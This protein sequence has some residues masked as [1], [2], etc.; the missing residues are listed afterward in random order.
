MLSSITPL[1]ERG[2]GNRWW[3]TVTAYLLGSVVGG[4]AL[5]LLAGTV[6]LAVARV[7]PDG[8]TLW[9]LAAGCLLAAV[10]DLGG[11][12]PPSWRRQVDEQWLHAF[13]G[14][15]YGFGFGVQ[16]GFGLVTIVTSAA[17][18]AAVLSMVLTGSPVAGALV[19]AVFGLARGLPVLAARR[20]VDTDSL[21]DL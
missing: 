15:V 2:K 7:L 10:W 11:R 4:A 3:L 21:R 19:G 18:Y 6:G 1:G 8:A 5:G 16:L 13:R 9:V 17:T 12:R 20:V 14:W